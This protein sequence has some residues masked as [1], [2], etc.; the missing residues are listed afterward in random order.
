MNRTTVIAIAAIATLELVAMA[1]GVNGA[2]LSTSMAII[3][4]LG[5]Y[6]VGRRKSK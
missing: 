6:E 2:A 5:G 4:G 3:G 1:C